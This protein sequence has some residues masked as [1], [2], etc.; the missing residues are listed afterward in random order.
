[1]KSRTPAHEIVLHPG[2]WWFGGG[3]TRARTVLGSCIA[4]TLWHPQLRVGGMCH[5]ML[6][7][8]VAPGSGKIGRA[9]V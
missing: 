2:D 4:I 9:H 6:P 1:M 8:R 5:Y 7:Q 3:D